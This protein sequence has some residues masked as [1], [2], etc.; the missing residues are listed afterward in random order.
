MVVNYK[1]AEF[2]P[3]KPFEP[4]LMF[5]G[6]AGVYPRGKNSGDL[7]SWPYPQTSDQDR[8]AFQGQTLQLIQPNGKKFN[9]IGPWGLHFK[10]L[11]IRCLREMDKFCCKLASSSFDRHASLEK[12]TSLSIETHQLIKESVNYESVMFYSSTGAN[13]IKLFCP[14]FTDFHTK[15]ECLLDQT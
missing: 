2:D 6:K 10:T 9:N 1:S 11:Q 3:G 14:L 7:G 12:H 8:N 5:S 13:V 4:S 15:L